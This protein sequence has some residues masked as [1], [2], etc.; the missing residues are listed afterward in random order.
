MRDMILLRAFLTFHMPICGAPQTNETQ[1]E[2]EN[3]LNPAQVENN[4]EAR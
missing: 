1:T 3:K 2:E 4:I